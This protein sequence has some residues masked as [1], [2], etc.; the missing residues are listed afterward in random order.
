MLDEAEGVKGELIGA[1]PPDPPVGLNGRD[2]VI[3]G[4]QVSLEILG[5]YKPQFI[6]EVKGLVA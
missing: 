5:L 4:S 3:S 6:E 1:S 2:L